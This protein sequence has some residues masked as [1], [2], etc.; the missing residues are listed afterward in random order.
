MPTEMPKFDPSGQKSRR[1]KG[2]AIR[3]GSDKRAPPPLYSPRP[4][5]LILIPSL[6]KT[7]VRPIPRKGPKPPG[8]YRRPEL[9]PRVPAAERPCSRSPPP[10]AP[11]SGMPPRHGLS[12]PEAPAQPAP[13]GRRG[14]PPPR[15]PHP[16]APAPPGRRP[17]ALPPPHRAPNDLRRNERAGELPAY[18][19]SRLGRFTSSRTRCYAVAVNL[20]TPVT[21]SSF[22]GFLFGRS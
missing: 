16:V 13:R 3:E 7:T 10:P 19:F 21:F 20:P 15:P 1:Y 22:S 12:R 8:S 18:D 2:Q 4:H 6:E 11:R 14:P 17:E 5:G 9:R